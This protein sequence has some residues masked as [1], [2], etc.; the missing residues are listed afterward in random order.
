[1]LCSFPLFSLVMCS[2]LQY[3]S[4]IASYKVLHLV[5]HL[6]FTI[7]NVMKRLV[8]IISGMVVFG[9]ALGFVN[10]FGVILS[11]V[12]I[13]VYNVVKDA[14]PNSGPSAVFSMAAWQSWVQG[15]VR[16]YNKLSEDRQTPGKLSANPSELDLMGLAT[17]NGAHA[18]SSGPSQQQRSYAWLQ[19]SRSMD[20]GFTSSSSF[21]DGHHASRRATVRAVSSVADDDPLESTP[22]FSPSNGAVVVPIGTHA[23]PARE[24]EALQ[25]G[26]AEKL[27]VV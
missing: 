13:L 6:T 24:R 25:A 20:S 3:L 7:V 22:S 14:A 21:H 17:A 1:M 10:T 16:A 15:V 23:G 9:Q 12:G 19:G 26:S 8:I 27:D 5:S 11:A 2:V 4:S 18:L